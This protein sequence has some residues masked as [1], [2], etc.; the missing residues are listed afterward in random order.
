MQPD[1]FDRQPFLVVLGMFGAVV[2]IQLTT[3]FFYWST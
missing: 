1:E 3:I 2:L